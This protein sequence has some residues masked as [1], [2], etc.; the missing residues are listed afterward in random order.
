MCVK[1]L[2]CDAGAAAALGPPIRPIPRPEAGGPPPIGAVAV[3]N[4]LVEVVGWKNGLRV[5]PAPP[6]DDEA[7]TP[8]IVALRRGA[9]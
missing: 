6:G 4:G 1:F 7:T 9:D 3:G 5:P 8:G 2:R